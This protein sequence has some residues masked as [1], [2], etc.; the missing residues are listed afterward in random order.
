MTLNL[1]FYH[2]YIGLNSSNL[3]AELTERSVASSFLLHEIR[4]NVS[5]RIKSA[6]GGAPL[7]LA[8]VVLLLVCFCLHM[9]H[10]GRLCICSGCRA[11]KWNCRAA[12]P[13]P[14]FEHSSTRLEQSTPCR[15]PEP[16]LI[17]LFH[18]QRQKE[19]GMKGT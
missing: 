19:P 3:T 13:S 8:G 6:V 16:F 11:G 10:V 7:L 18:T 14:P 5:V 15:T 9:R 4:C 1:A 17:K 12:K 2:V